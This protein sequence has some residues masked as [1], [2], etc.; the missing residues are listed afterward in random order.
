MFSYTDSIM[1]KNPKLSIKDITLLN[2]KEFLISVFFPLQQ[3]QNQN[4]TLRF[5]SMNA[6]Q[7]KLGE[8]KLMQ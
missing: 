5:L 1:K 8:Q 4:V 6:F 7:N 2:V 3:Y